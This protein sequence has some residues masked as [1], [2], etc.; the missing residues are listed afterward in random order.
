[1][2]EALRGEEMM[3]DE[4]MEVGGFVLSATLRKEAAAR[5]AKAR[6]RLSSGAKRQCAKMAKLSRYKVHSAYT[7]Q[8]LWRQGHPAL[9]ALV[10][11]TGKGRFAFA[12]ALVDLACLGAKDAYVFTNLTEGEVADHLEY[13][14]ASAGSMEPTD[15]AL[16]AALIHEGV[17]LRLALGLKLHDDL[18]PVLALIRGVDHSAHVGELPLGMNGKLVL[19]PGPFDDGPKLLEKIQGV[20]GAGMVEYIDE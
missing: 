18:H 19:I 2:P 4:E 9:S 7:N 11:E 15:P 14:S 10:I 5:F 1:V 16:A 13:M 8:E 6:Q 3:G 17:T 12:H 20:V